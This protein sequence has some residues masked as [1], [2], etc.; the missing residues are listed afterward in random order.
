MRIINLDLKSGIYFINICRELLYP[1]IWGRS[2]KLKL[3]KYVKIST[4]IYKN[5][6]MLKE[7]LNSKVLPHYNRWEVISCTVEYK[8]A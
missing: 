4:A 6:S 5:K 1:F 2:A 8:S 7:I 3:M